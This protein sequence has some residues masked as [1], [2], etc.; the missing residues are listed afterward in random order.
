MD[1]TLL[2]VR[3]ELRD[4]ARPADWADILA[5][6]PVFAGISKR[7]LRELAKDATFEEHGRGDFVIQRGSRGDSLFVILSGSATALGKRAAETLR[8]GDYFGEMGALEGAPRSATIVA[9][10]ELHV[11]RLPRAA[12]LR[13]ARRE[14]TVSLRMLSGLGSRIRRLE[15]LPAQA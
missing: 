10:G 4:Y 5:T 13:L 14:P 1:L 11:M 6:F 12:F 3:L 9:A 15:A 7:R 8:T 2:P